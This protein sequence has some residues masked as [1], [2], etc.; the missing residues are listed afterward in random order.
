MRQ[1][2][3]LL[4]AKYPEPGRA[5]T[6]LISAV[7]A[8]GAAG[9]SRAFTDDTVELARS[10]GDAGLELWISGGAEADDFFAQR[11]PGLP[12]RRQEGEDLGERLGEAFAAVFGESVDYAVVIGSDHPTLP[13]KYIDRAFAA[14]IGAHLVIGPSRDGGYYLIGLRRYAWPQAR[15]LFQGMPWSTTRLLDATREAARRLDLCHVE[16]PEWYDVDGPSDLERLRRD[17]QPGSRTATA[18]D[19]LVPDEAP[20]GGD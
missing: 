13:A 10:V 9:L 14:L 17:V 18:L 5:K 11:Y 15:G 3:L 16:L 4:F 8:E 7:G 1:R 12:V 20:R 19:G 2:R 6:R